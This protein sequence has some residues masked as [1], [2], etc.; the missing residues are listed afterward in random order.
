MAESHKGCQNGGPDL[1]SCHLSYDVPLSFPCGGSDCY[2]SGITPCPDEICHIDSQ[3][4]VVY[5]PFE[6]IVIFFF[7]L[8]LVNVGRLSASTSWWFERH[9]Q[10]GVV[11][12]SAVFGMVWLACGVTVLGVKCK[13]SCSMGG[14]EGGSVTGIG[15][16]CA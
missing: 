9:Y 4:I 16:S 15:L 12:E 10:K 11:L 6:I 2:H 3:C 1:D 8:F 14:M 5:C 13:W 7:L